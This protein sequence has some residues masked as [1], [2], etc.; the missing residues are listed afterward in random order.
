LISFTEEI[1][2]YNG[3]R[4]FA[5]EQFYPRRRGMN[6]ELQGVEVEDFFLCDNDFAVEHTASR[7]LGGDRLDQFG[8]VAVQRFFIAALNQDL[9]AIAKHQ[10][11]KAI[12]LGLENPSSGLR[13]LAHALGEHRQDRRVHGEIHT[14]RSIRSGC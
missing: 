1:E 11:A 13:Q 8:K 4:D 5:R 2:K 7:E 14:K 6:A 3:R 12:P 10:R 9:V